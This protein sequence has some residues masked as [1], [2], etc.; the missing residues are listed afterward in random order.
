MECKWL[1]GEKPWIFE[2][3]FIK[4]KD[5]DLVLGVN[6]QSNK[7]TIQKFWYP[8]NPSQKW[9]KRGIN[10]DEDEDENESETFDPF[11]YQL[12]NEESGKFLT[13]RESSL[14]VENKGKSTC[15]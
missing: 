12:V 1:Y 13:A 3:G 15:K 6:G 10:W 14:T 9:R 2:E 7:V 8:V 4:Q 11:L 5:T